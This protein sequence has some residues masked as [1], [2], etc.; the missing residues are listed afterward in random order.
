[1]AA[2]PPVRGDGSPTLLPLPLAL[3][4]GYE[5]MNPPSPG[6]SSHGPRRPDQCQA[7]RR[8]QAPRH[9]RRRRVSPACRTWRL[10]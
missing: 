4:P 8:S 6:R 10:A 2:G 3:L 9:E 5:H 1:M 7:H